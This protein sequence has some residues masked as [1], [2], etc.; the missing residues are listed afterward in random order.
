MQDYEQLGQFYLGKEVDSAKGGV[1]DS[2]LLYDSRDMTTHAV[3]VGMTGSGKTGLCVGLLEEAAI[4]GIPALIIDPKGDLGNLLLAFPGLQ[5][6]EFR[7]WVD[8]DEAARQGLSVEDF[9]ARTAETW[10]KGLADWGQD[11]ARIARLRDAVDMAIYTPGSTAGLPLSVLRSFSAPSP[12]VLADAAVLRDRI[13]ACVS[14]LLGMAGVSADPVKS[15][16]H[17]LLANILDQAWR[18]GRSLDIPALIGAIQKPPFEKVGVFD[19]ETF[20]PA[21]DRL[22]L[23][24]ALNNL[25]ASPG[26]STWLEGEPL[27]IQRLLYTPAGKPRLS[28]VSIA[29]LSDTERMFVVTLLLNE[30][31]SWMRTQS[32]TTSL[33]ALLYMDEIFGYFPPSAMPPSKMPMLTLLKQARAFGVGVVLSTQNPVD[34]DYKGLANAGTW[35]IGRLQ[36]DRD[37]ARVMD[38]L[39]SAIPNGFDRQKLEGMMSQLGKRT[40]L[41]HNVHDDHPVLFQSRWTLSYLRGPMTPKQIQSVMEG[42]KAQAPAEAQR[43]GGTPRPTS[44][45][46][47][48]PAV[49]QPV[50]R[51]A[52]PVGVPEYFVVGARPAKLY[53]PGVVAVSKLHFVEAKS[54][55][56]CWVPYVHVAPFSAA[57]TDVAWET[58]QVLERGEEDLDSEPAPGAGFSELPA[59]ALR[60]KN[61]ESWAKSLK[62]WLYQG[63]AL[64]LLACEALKAVSKPGETEGDFRARLAVS[65]REKRDVEVEKLRRTYAPKLATVQEQLRRAQARVAAEK[66]QMGQQAM[67]TAISI[68]A[69]VLGA[70]FGRKTMSVGNMGRAATAMRGAGR[71]LRERGDI[72]RADESVAAVQSRLDAL[73]QEFS[74]ETLRIQTGCDPASLDITTTRIRPRKT[75][76]TVPVI[77]LAWIG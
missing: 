38:G 22:E 32:G 35:L 23:A 25:L 64:D 65:L 37:K 61:Y 15:R 21:K 43:L 28:I 31:V 74:Q 20:Y 53:R 12:E 52:A 46:E 9:A 26:F 76:I 7:P 39:E 59:A 54:D 17:I 48:A 75:D 67:Q 51:P 41:M 68:G 13:T 70:F 73:E 5:P 44:I 45:P 69:T 3:C 50:S 30:M 2:L 71:T 16:E 18:A 36:T 57:G 1:S 40:F 60:A 77:A 4:D 58:A 14:G 24:M 27:D 11:A 6:S 8:P 49:V 62:S 56:D 33:R 55:V 34:L 47:S 19:V 10:R 72:Q 66:S 42:R 63:V 29:H